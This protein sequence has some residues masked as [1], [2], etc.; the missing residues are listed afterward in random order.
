[1]HGELALRRAAQARKAAAAAFA[2]RVDLSQSGLVSKQAARGVRMR[3]VHVS[4]DFRLRPARLLLVCALLQMAAS[5][6]AQAQA[7][8][9]STVQVIG[10]RAPTA[11]NRVVADVVVID[12]DRIRA[13]SADSV[14]D[15]LRR[16]GGIQLSRNGGPGQNASVLIRGSGASSTLVLIDGVRVG[17]ATL[18]Q[19]DLAAISLAQV[20]RIEIMRGPGSS[21]YGADA[22]GGV[23]NIVTR[24]GDGAPYVHGNLA[25]GN[26]AS[27]EASVAFSGSGEGF[28]YALSA[29]GETSD[30]VSAVLPGD[31]FGIYNPD[32]DG[33]TRYG[34]SLAG[35]FS[36]QKGQRIGLNYSASRL[37]SQFDSAEYPPP[38][39]LPDPSPDFRSR[40]T[41]QLTALEYQGV[42]SGEWTNL[43]RASYQTDQLE[44]GA[45]VV[46][47]YDTSRRQFT[48]QTT[49]TPSS[50]HQ[51]VAAI[52]LLTESI[53]SSDYSAPQ[54]DNT[55]LIVGYTGRFGA[56]KLQADLR[57]DHNSV[58]D[59][60]TTGKLGWGMDF[61]PG[62]S[63]RAVA[64]T[65]FRAPTFNDLYYPDYG[66]VSLS[67]ER[68]HS[69]EAGIDYRAETTSVAAT[70]YYNKVSD[71]IG[72]QADPSQCPPG[73]NFGC[74]DNTARALLQGITLQ[75]LQQL[76]NFQFTLALDWL[77]AKDT[78]TDQTLPR[79]AA[80]Q[81]TFAV[82]WN[83][84]PWQLGGTVLRVSQRPDAGALLPAYALLNLNARWRFERAW[85]L[86]ARLQ[87]AFDKDY[88]PARD[89]QDVGR[90][91]WLGLRYDGRGL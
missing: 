3:K 66:V 26:H 71:L 9:G 57:W 89:Y 19:T 44:S 86:E 77:N 45:N 60:Q 13:T 6:W 1:M 47:T 53:H 12:R 61:G 52:D 33:F 5:S 14:E 69:V 62:W 38:N 81:Q 83:E 40:V 80:N 49:W 74:A 8:P 59:D 50:Q 87:N 34:L 88:Q 7:N 84:G 72:Y 51:L 76:G 43:L 15:L 64:G 68:S 2:C 78:D 41:T 91:F 73:F 39:F 27:G 90:Q 20:E 29:S 56:Q 42:V 32:D 31:L 54:R 11:L 82:D 75:A 30:G 36:W 79:R 23:V 67:P 35:G 63:V 28:D 65:A 58:Y 55:G 24:R 46:S 37:R 21:L 17:S 85:Q 18:G 4:S 22:I 48:A 70:A 25:G 16:E 10:T